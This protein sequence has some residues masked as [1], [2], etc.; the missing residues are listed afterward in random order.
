MTKTLDAKLADIHANPSTSRGF[1]LA[2]AKDADM[3]WGIGSAGKPYPPP[4]HVIEGREHRPISALRDDT[5]QIV[6]AGLVDVMLASVSTMATLAHTERLFEGSPVTPAVRMN[7]TSDIWCGR[8]AKYRETAS[9]PFATAY[10]EEAMYGTL[11]PAKQASPV[12]D[13]GLY[14]MTFNNDIDADHRSLVAF[15][16][17]RAEAQQKGLRYFLE[18]FAPNLSCDR[19][20]L[21]DEQIPAFLNDML[22]RTL[23][24]VPPAG[25]PLFLKIPYFGPRWMEELVNYDPTIVVGVLGGSSGTTYDAFKLLSEAQKHGARVA[26]FGRKIKDAEDPMEF[27]AMLRRI[28]EGEISPENAVAAYHGFL[29]GKR[30]PPKRALAKDMELTSAE[31]SYARRD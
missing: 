16:E 5:R 2:D 31:L 25:R 22:V 18:V 3:A 30:I 26:L 24:A 19:C 27:I 4:A 9:I 8:G 20:G 17:F 1:I 13:L 11:A 6:Q 10:I 28:V 14:S 21:S 7:D 23:A 29:Q 12:V 15:K